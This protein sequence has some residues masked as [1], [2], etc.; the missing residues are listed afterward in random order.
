MG[1][2]RKGNQGEVVRRVGCPVHS[3]IYIYMGNWNIGVLLRVI[4][5]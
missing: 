5:E 1:M 2:G 4:W 3:R